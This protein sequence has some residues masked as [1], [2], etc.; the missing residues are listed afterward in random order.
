M[1]QEHSGDRDLFDVAPDELGST[2]VDLT[3]IDGEVV[4]D[5]LVSGI[6]E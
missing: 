3:M 5:R 4:Y 6:P 2:Q 1:R